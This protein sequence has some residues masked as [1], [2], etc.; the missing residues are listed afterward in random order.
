MVSTE[1]RA[2][3]KKSLARRTY[4]S[5]SVIVLAT[6]IVVTSP[7]ECSVGPPP[8]ANVIQQLVGGVQGEVEPALEDSLPGKE[9]GRMSLPY[10]FTPKAHSLEKYRALGRNSCF[11]CPRD[12]NTGTN[13]QRV[14]SSSH[15]NLDF[16][17]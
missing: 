5:S 11:F 16:L 9:G 8:V 1:L 4:K 7:L 3:K 10:S 6:E 12:L 17:A 2:F 15:T 13:L 14:S